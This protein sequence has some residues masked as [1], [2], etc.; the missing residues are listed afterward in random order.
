[1]RRLN[2]DVKEIAVGENFTAVVSL[3][4]PNHYLKD[5]VIDYTWSFDMDQYFTSNNS[6]IYN[7]SDVGDKTIIVKPKATLPNSQTISGFFYKQLKAEG[8]LELCI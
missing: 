7:F 2:D 8:M 4:D 1:M 5:A 6:F 3:H